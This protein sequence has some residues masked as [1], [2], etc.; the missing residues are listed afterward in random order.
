MSSDKRTNSS[1]PVWDRALKRFQDEID[2]SNDFQAVI[3]EGSLQGLLD[4][5]Q[6]A[7]VCARERSAATNM[8]RLGPILRFVNDFAAVIAVSSGTDP[9]MTAIVW[10][11]IRLLISLGSS[12]G[13]T[14]QEIMDML[15]ELSLTL[16]RFHRYEKTLPMDESFESTLF[17]VYTEMICLCAR[18]IHFLRSNPHNLLRRSAWNECQG[19]FKRTIKRIK[20]LSAA[21][22][23]EADLARMKR[24]EEKYLEA[25]NVVKDLRLSS[26]NQDLAP[27]RWCVPRSWMKYFWGREE[28]LEALRLSLSKENETNECR[29]SALHGMGGVGKTQIA[30]KCA[31]AFAQE[32]CDVFWVAAE[33]TMTLHQ[34][35]TELC[36]QLKLL[37]K[38]DGDDEGVDGAGTVYKF[39]TWLADASEFHH[40]RK[41]SHVR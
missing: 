35:C 2:Q 40:R 23:T 3:E 27:K 21:V 39:K 24:E 37:E 36:R 30:L 14:L 17:E 4:Y 22:E 31:S 32:G 7:Q 10:G 26:P 6:D 11:S 9:K 13:D 33:N 19:D 38:G 12:A 8:N 15:E 41:Q 34:S 18:L 5:A 29:V 20:R 25:I 1:S 16:P 28:Q